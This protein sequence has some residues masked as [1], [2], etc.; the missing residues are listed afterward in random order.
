[1]FSI[2]I[3]SFFKSCFSNIVYIVDIILHANIAYPRKLTSAH[4]ALRLLIYGNP[5]ERKAVLDLIKSN[6]GKQSY[7]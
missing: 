5:S 7:V 4:L 1:M 2:F 3:G 6:L